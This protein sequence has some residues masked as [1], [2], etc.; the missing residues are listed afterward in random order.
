MRKTF[1]LATALYRIKEHPNPKY[2][3]EQ[4]SITPW[5]AAEILLKAQ[6]DI[7]NKVVYDLGCGTGRFAIGAALLGARKVWG[8]DVDRDALRVARANTQLIESLTGRPVTHIIRWE[9]AD[10]RRLERKCDTVVQFPPFGTDLVF[11]TKAV[12]MAKAVYSVHK[13]TPQIRPKL[14]QICAD[15]GVRITHMKEFKYYLP[16]WGMGK[17]G[18][19]VLFV[20]AKR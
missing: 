5:I 15:M 11:F 2:F 4:Y 6:P 9:L 14:Q 16:W 8:I 17:T 18:Y 7:E 3:L 10:V 12:Q 20:I 1:T 19:G 13:S